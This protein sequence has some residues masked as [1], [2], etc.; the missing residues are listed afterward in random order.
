MIKNERQLN[1]A[2]KRLADLDAALACDMPDSERES[3]ERLAS[4]VRHQ[5][6][7]YKAIKSGY[8][9]T[10]SVRGLDTLP[11]ALIKARIA[12]GLTHRQL[13]DR[14]GVSEQMVQRDESGG[15]ETAS[16]DRLADTADALGYALDGNLSPRWTTVPTYQTG[17][18]F[19]FA[20]VGLAASST[21]C[22]TPPAT[23]TVPARVTM[24]EALA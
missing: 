23:T 4:D 14:L 9:R 13:A 15:Y 6:H 21:E 2:Q 19:N 3:F 8:I 10:F 20:F 18:V 5:V 12:L 16:L 1:I 17:S 24:T 22:A 11:D 7:E